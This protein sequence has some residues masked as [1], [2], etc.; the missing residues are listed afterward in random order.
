MK[1]AD[2]EIGH[3]NPPFLIAEASINHNGSLDRA[4]KM[5]SV[6]KAAGCNAVKFQT[7]SAVDVCDPAQM[8]TYQ[9]QGKE[10]TEPRINIFLRTELPESAWPKLKAECD[11]VSILFMSTPETPNDL[12]ILLRV[13]IPAIKIGSD[14]LTNL[15]MLRYCARDDVNL[16]ILLSCGMGSAEELKKAVDIIIAITI[17]YI[18]MVCTSEY[19]CPSESVNL[20]RV[21]KMIKTFGN[22]VGF[23]DHTIGSLAACLALAAGASVFE[24]HFTLDN[25]LPG[26]EHSWAKNPTELSQWVTDI[27]TAHTM[28]GSGIIA[29]SKAELENKARYQRTGVTYG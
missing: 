1:I 22:P 7:F 28:M 27:R 4:I 26:P 5:I 23:S 24:T 14:N 25:N 19:P 10:V 29:P 15:P 8:Y 18:P 20:L 21:S 11:R 2:Y 13:G 16:P 17:A 9:S 3:G 12:D 6:A